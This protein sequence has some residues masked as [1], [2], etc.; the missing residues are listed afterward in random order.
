MED[1]IFLKKNN[2]WKKEKSNINKKNKNSR[3]LNKRNDNNYEV[4]NKNSFNN[5]IKEEIK[6]DENNFPELKV[7]KKEEPVEKTQIESKWKKAI[8]KQSDKDKEIINVNDPKY[9]RGHIWIG[10]ICLKQDKYSES[11]N[12]YIKKAQQ[13]CASTIIFPYQKTQYSRDNVN[14][15]NSFEETFTEEQLEKMNNQKKEEENNKFIDNIN[16]QLSILYE[17]RKRESI[18]Y[19][20][21]T[22]ELDSFAIAELEREEYEK[23]E[24]QFE[25]K[26][27]EEEKEKIIEN[28][29]SDEEYDNDI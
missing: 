28:T 5:K 24:K 18:E 3:Y 6:F 9:W 13:S 15:F 2:R 4:V 16:R 20:E 23:Y 22:G 12:K 21:M 29:Y 1:N 14:W 19:Y 11:W 7:E 17:K 8:M 27:E 25:M 10:P 26:E